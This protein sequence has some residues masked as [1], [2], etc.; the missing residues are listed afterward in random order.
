MLFRS[1]NYSGYQVLAQT[2]FAWKH[3]QEYTIAVTVNENKITAEIDGT[4]LEVIDEERPYLQ[5]SIGVSMQNGSHD[6]YRTIKVKG[7]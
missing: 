2:A 4:V 6:K 5:G 3:G 7:F 1:K